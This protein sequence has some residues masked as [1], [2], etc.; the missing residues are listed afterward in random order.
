MSWQEINEE[1]VVS[2]EEQERRRKFD[3]LVYRVFALTEPGRELMAC[4]EVHYHTPVCTPEK[5]AEWGFF[6]EGQ[7]SIIRQFKQAV[8]RQDHLS[9]ETKDGK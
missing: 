8:E 7:N 1:P 3:S 4:L 6:R 9:R 5:S 2:T